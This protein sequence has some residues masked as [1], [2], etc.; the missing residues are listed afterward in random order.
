MFINSPVRLE[1]CISRKSS[2]L[3]DRTTRSNENRFRASAFILRVAC[4]APHT[5]AVPLASIGKG[6]AGNGLK[7]VRCRMKTRFVAPILASS[8]FAAGAL[9]QSPSLSTA[10][11]DRDAVAPAAL[12]SPRDPGKQV[13][14][15]ATLAPAEPAALPYPDDQ[16]EQLDATA[17]A[18]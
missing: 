2:V 1:H 10:G 11:A 7:R 8:I 17:I 9:A 14:D 3:A 12:T 18:A 5:I 15:A 16:F 6:S 13:K 4:E